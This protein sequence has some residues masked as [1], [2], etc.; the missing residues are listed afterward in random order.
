MTSPH[1]TLTLD[2]AV[3][4]AFEECAL[5]GHADEV[6]PWGFIRRIVHD[7]HP[8]HRD[9]NHGL[10]ALLLGVAN[11]GV[12]LPS[13]RR[14]VL[15]DPAGD[16]WRGRPPR[17]GKH[18]L[19]G[20]SNYPYGGIGIAHFDR[21]RWKDFEARW[22]WLGFD[23]RL[24]FDQALDDEKARRAM[25]EWSDR[26]LGDLENHVEFVR[27]WI[28][29][30]WRPAMMAH[31][32]DYATA[33]VNAR[34]RNSASAVGAAAAGK[35]MGRQIRDYV[36][37]KRTRSESAAERAAKQARYA[38]RVGVIVQAASEFPPFD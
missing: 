2:E 22:G 13:E 30:Y 8:D 4:H 19:D 10:L 38:Q 5:Q 35:S 24:S 14:G 15:P 31:P 12:L 28:A 27:I 16:G 29:R 33:A 1:A 9:D 36:D 25:L 6:L 11:M 32:G 34:I 3:R 18:W 23:Y 21:S 37:Y 20:T 7:S 26:V 17:S